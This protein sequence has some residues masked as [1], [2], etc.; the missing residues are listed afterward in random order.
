[1]ARSPSSLCRIV[2]GGCNDLALDQQSFL[3]FFAVFYDREPTKAEN[4][5]EALA[6][7]AADIAQEPQRLNIRIPV[8]A[9]DVFMVVIVRD[10][11]RGRID[12]R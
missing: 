9:V 1:M 3:Q 12:A 6:R 4:I 11:Q 5:F 7:D 2:V 8:M 10:I